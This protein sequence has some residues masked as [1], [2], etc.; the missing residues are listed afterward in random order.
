MKATYGRRDGLKEEWILIHSFCKLLL[1]GYF[2]TAT[3]KETK[4]E[5]ITGGLIATKVFKEGVTRGAGGLALQGV[6]PAVS[7]KGS[8]ETHH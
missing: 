1:L 6:T 5:S 4:T 3:G 7:V 2:L 8:F